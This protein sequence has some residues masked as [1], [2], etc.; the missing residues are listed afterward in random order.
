[1]GNGASGESG[2]WER[3]MSEVHEVSLRHETLYVASSTDRRPLCLPA[4]RSDC[5]SAIR[6]V[7]YFNQGVRDTTSVHAI[8]K[9]RLEPDLIDA[10][11]G[12][13]DGQ[14]VRL[15]LGKGSESSEEGRIEAANC[16][17]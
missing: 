12:W 10:G 9:F 11:Q 14:I 6:P 5:F 17:K 15:F 1:M 16:S 2:L 4:M 13:Q 7:G 8:S 3:V